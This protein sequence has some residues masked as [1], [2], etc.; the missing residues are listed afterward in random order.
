MSYLPLIMTSGGADVSTQMVVLLGVVALSVGL[1]AGLVGMTLGI[2]TLPVMLAVGINPLIAAGTNLGL[3]VLGSTA[4]LWAHARARRV[5]MRVALLFG[6]PAIA[7]AFIGGRFAHL[8]PVWL[9]FFLVAFFLGWSAL[10]I[11][12][13][14]LKGH[15][16]IVKYPKDVP[17][18]PEVSPFR[19]ASRESALQMSIGGV[20]G[21]VGGAAGV[22]LGTVRMPAL[23]NVLKM[24]PAHAI[25]TNIMIGILAGV[26]GFAGHLINNNIDWPLLGIMGGA[27]M[28]G[29]FIGSLFTG[30]LNASQLRVVIGIV[31]LVMTPVMVFNGVSELV[32]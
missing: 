17:Q 4:A 27:S 6:L 16:R 3:T 21:V 5:V 29:N 22:V 28:T 9:L 32:N 12:M 26:F 24:D 30:R 31:L 14:A 18:Q 11:L 20:I 15:R 8:A 1:L 19:F 10:N 13:A 2:V 7:G 23:I 25:G